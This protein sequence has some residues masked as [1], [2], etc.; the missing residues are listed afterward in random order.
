MSNHCRT[1]LA[2]YLCLLW[3][4]QCLTASAGELDAWEKQRQRLKREAISLFQAVLQEELDGKPDQCQFRTK[5]ND[6]AVP[7]SIAHEYFGVKVPADLTPSSEAGEPEDILDPTGTIRDAFC[8]ELNDDLRLAY[9]I[10]SFRRGE[11]T[12][13]VSP[14]SHSSWIEIFRREH[15]FPIFDKDYRR[16][17]IISTGTRRFWYKR[18]GRFRG[19]LEGGAFASI[20][21]KRHGRWQLLKHEFLSSWHG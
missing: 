9:V 11:P 17:V 13:E 15:T 7:S 16:A 20:Y 21:Q 1:I 18:D 5:W 19:G 8:D 10:E 4:A 3:L 12:A 14:R 2:L 6:Y